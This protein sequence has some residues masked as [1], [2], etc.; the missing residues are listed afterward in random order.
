VTLVTQHRLD[1]MVGGWFVGAF[2]PVALHCEAAEVA[3]KHYAAGDVEDSHE[4]RI[5]TEVTVLVSGR[6]KMCGRDLVAGDVL[7]L[8]PGTA[9]GFLALTDCTTVAVKTP[10]V[11]GDKHAAPPSRA[12]WQITPGGTR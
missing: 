11:L 6:A 8:E 3:V 12:D 10:S 5:A 9:T 2:T 4:H 7:V 1:E